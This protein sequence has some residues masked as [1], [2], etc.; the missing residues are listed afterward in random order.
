V[1]VSCISA[2]GRCAYCRRGMYGQCLGGGGWILGR[3]INGVQAQYARIPF[4]DNGLY[5]VPDGLTDE[6]VLQ[7]ADILPTGFE[8]G[9]LKGAV[10]PGD[11][12]AV[13]GAGPVGLAAVMTAGLFGP[14]RSSRS[15]CPTG[16]WPA[17]SG[18]ARTARSMR[19]PA[20]PP[21]RCGS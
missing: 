21:R 4:A 14:S 5:R 13:V 6:H 17:P 2:C 9:V 3:M 18:S 7:L 8:V 12:V 15:T 10:K 16:A 11:T 19:D 20:T 1:L